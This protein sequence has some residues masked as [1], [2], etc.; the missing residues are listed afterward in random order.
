MPA[1][2]PIP[3]AIRVFLAAPRFATLATLNDDGGPHQAITWYLL[4]GDALIVNSR[5]ERRWPRNL[6]RDPRAH[7]AVHDHVQL[8]H[9]VGLQTRAEVLR[10][11]DAAI[12]DIAAM[13]GRYGGDPEGFRGQN[14]ITFTLRIERSYEY[15]S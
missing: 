14:R 7:V 5:Q 15:W 11:G 12:E 4:E 1:A 8:G 3:E 6:Q 10:T 13:A 9:W 2:S